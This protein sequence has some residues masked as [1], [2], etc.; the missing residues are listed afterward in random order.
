MVQIT[1]GHHF[2]KYK[3]KLRESIN[4][5]GESELDY[6]IKL[7]EK[8][9]LKKFHNPKEKGFVAYQFD[10]KLPHEN[11]EPI[12]SGVYDG[13][14]A[15]KFIQ[16]HI[17]GER[18]SP[19]AGQIKDLINQMSDIDKFALEL[20]G[21][22][23]KLLIDQIIVHDYQD[24]IFIP[25]NSITLIFPSK[26]ESRTLMRYLNDYIEKDFEILPDP[27]AQKINEDLLCWLAF[28]ICHEKNGDLGNLKI[29]HLDTIGQTAFSKSG[30]LNIAEVENVCDIIYSKISF[31]LDELSKHLKI[32]VKYNDKSYRFSLF[33]KG[34]F[35]PDWKS[36]SSY[37]TGN[38]R[39]DKLLNIRDIAQ[40]IVPLIHQEYI[41]DK[42]T[43]DE[44]KASLQDKSIESAKKQLNEL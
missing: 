2:Y 26:D 44:E 31:G 25:D 36:P 18:R 7:F 37:V 24:F 29:T 41:K 21:Q 33:P 19:K 27:I 12:Q 10:P 40:E 42:K 14:L 17:K 20:K 22:I 16:Y 35:I 15:I 5:K 13:M 30:E 1:G 23:K 32:T 8:N 39:T 3:L 34:F 9:Q 6:L 38:V 28:K 11:I 4:L 43:W